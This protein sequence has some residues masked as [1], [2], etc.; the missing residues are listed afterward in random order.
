M[1]LELSN[2]RGRGA[3]A[4]ERASARE[5]ARGSKGPPPPESKVPRQSHSPRSRHKNSPRAWDKQFKATQVLETYAA[6]LLDGEDDER[7]EKRT[8][9]ECALRR[10]EYLPVFPTKARDSV[11]VL[12]VVTD[13]ANRAVRCVSS[14]TA[15]DV[16]G[17]A[18]VGSYVRMHIEYAGY[19]LEELGDRKTRMTSVV[20]LDPRG[21][22]PNRATHTKQGTWMVLP[23]RRLSKE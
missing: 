15:P 22:V 16:D 10:Y 7:G 11:A 2:T 8:G 3:D 1:T 4:P 18:E 12:G 21:A 20:V 9:L 17:A 19:Y 6:C 14:V 5:R 23:P 13:G